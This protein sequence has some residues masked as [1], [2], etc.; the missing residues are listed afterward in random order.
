MLV[1]LKNILST[2]VDT[3]FIWIFC[4]IIVFS[5]LIHVVHYCSR[6]KP[7][8]LKKIVRMLARKHICSTLVDTGVIW[9]LI[10]LWFLV[11]Y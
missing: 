9:V 11:Y 8:D 4:K 1:R 6:P 10:K 5:V 3:E 7:K 2:L